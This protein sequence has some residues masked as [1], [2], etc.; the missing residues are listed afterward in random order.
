MASMKWAWW[1]RRRPLWQRG[2]IAGLRTFL[3]KRRKWFTP[4][5]ILSNVASVL[6][7]LILLLICNFIY[8]DLTSDAY[9]IDPISVPEQYDKS[10]LN[11]QVMSRRIG[12]ALRSIEEN[13]ETGLGRD[14]LAISSDVPQL[15]AVEVPGTKLDL[16]TL[17]DLVRQLFGWEQRRITGE[18]VLRIQK[19][20][21]ASNN[22]E[23]ETNLRIVHGGDS[24][25][26]KQILTPFSE[27]QQLEQS[28]A[29]QILRSINPLILAVYDYD[30]GEREKASEIAIEI[31]GD[32]ARDKLH[33][34]AAQ[35]L[36]GLVLDDQ[37]KHQ[38]AI[39]RYR[40]AI[41][42]DPGFSNAYLNWGL[43]LQGEGDFDGAIVKYQKAIELDAKNSESYNNWGAILEAF[44]KD[45]EAVAKYQ[46]AIESDPKNVDPYMSWGS[47]FVKERKYEDALSKYLKAI[48]VNPARAGPYVGWGHL[49]AAQG[50]YAEAIPKYQK[51][52]ELSPNDSSAYTAWGDAL[53]DQGKYPEAV[54]KY[55]K[56]LELAPN[57][58]LAF[59]SL[60]HAF[61]L[62]GKF[63]E[64]VR[65]YQKAIAADPHEARPYVEW[66]FELGRQREYVEALA[67]RSGNPRLETSSPG[68]CSAEFLR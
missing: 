68:R 25:Q 34:A 29:E 28:A 44:G 62:Q 52:L 65:Q 59:T 46:K 32:A 51:A 66:G 4:Q 27:P 16:R 22:R 19:E 47:I 43:A 55:Q 23:T 3:W 30:R 5:H 31:I 54:A 61:A 18:V 15:P 36:W 58:S 56:A 49:L 17:V 53:A 8:R 1:R 57:K 11:A 10:G 48:E 26:L 38:E 7:I 35:D 45:Q 2:V 37:G 42:L 41:E 20:S 50:N 67:A 64:A 12:Q 6:G 13:A 14:R 39:A 40:K 60:G 33:I 24:K 9:I 63:V 21:D